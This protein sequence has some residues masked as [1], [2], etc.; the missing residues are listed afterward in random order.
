MIHQVILSPHLG[1][2]VYS[3]EG[4]LHCI[5]SCADGFMYV[6]TE[7]RYPRIIISCSN[8]KNIMRLTIDQSN[9]N[10]TG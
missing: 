6:I 7:F 5:T 9:Q 10:S 2:L 8:V 4:E 1:G 3:K